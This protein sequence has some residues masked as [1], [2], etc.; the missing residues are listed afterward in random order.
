MLQV[1]AMVSFRHKQNAENDISNL[2]LAYS[3]T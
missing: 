2:L 3:E 1:V